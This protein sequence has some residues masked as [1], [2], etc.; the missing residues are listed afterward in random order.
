MPYGPVASPRAASALG[1]FQDKF[2]YAD[3]Y[4]LEPYDLKKIDGKLTVET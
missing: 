1:K 4:L 3:G 2:F